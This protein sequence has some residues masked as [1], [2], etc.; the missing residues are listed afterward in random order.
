MTALDATSVSCHIFVSIPFIQSSF[1]AR[2][3]DFPVG[4]P[5]RDSFTTKLDL[6]NSPVV[7]SESLS[8]DLHA[9]VVDV[10]VRSDPRDGGPVLSHS[11]AD[12]KVMQ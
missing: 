2:R 5:Y 6:D 7:R 12:H 11:F 3:P 10:R 1:Y 8:I 9:R 4:A